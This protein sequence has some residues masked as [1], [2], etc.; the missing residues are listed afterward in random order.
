LVANGGFFSSTARFS[1]PIVVLPC[2]QECRIVPESYHSY[3]PCVRIIAA[4][5]YGAADVRAAVWLSWLLWGTGNAFPIGTTLVVVLGR[6]DELFSG[7]VG[8]D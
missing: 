5:G 7:T 1:S 6:D 8:N 2:Y 3:C 4:D